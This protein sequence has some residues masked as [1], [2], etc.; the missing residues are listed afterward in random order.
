MVWWKNLTLQIEWHDVDD[1]VDDAGDLGHG[2]QAWELCQKGWCLWANWQ[3]TCGA[4]GQTR[5]LM[6]AR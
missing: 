1:D 3:L 6:M 2:E 4:G 5:Q